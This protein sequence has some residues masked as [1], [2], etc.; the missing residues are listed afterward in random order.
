[1]TRSGYLILDT[2]RPNGQSPSPT[3]Q[4]S[5]C[6]KAERTR[7]Y[8]V[9]VAVDRAGILRMLTG[10]GGHIWMFAPNKSLYTSKIAR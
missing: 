9:A 6:P 8:G 3:V 2:Q 5:N 7:V 10:K 4:L 1:M